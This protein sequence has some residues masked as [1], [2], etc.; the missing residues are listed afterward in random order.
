MAEM[1]L[2]TQQMMG[3]PIHGCFSLRTAQMRGLTDL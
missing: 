2:Q 3:S 1:K